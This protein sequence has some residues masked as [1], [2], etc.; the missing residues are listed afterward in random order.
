MR[1]YLDD[2]IESHSM[3][4]SVVA[5]CSIVLVLCVSLFGYHTVAAQA[6]ISGTA[7]T[8]LNLSICGNM[9]VDV[10]EQC[11]VPGENGA[12]STT[13]VGR[14]CNVSCLYGPYCGDGILQTQYSE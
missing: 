3:K 6:V 2:R 14:Q 10:V 12:Y 8:S 5:G 7:T 13:I 9:L 11:D 4:L 1:V